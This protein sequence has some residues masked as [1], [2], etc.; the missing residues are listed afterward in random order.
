ME[1]LTRAKALEK[2]RKLREQLESQDADI[3]AIEAEIQQIED[4]LENLADA[5]EELAGGE[6]EREDQEDQDNPED[7]GQ[8]DDHKDDPEERQSLARQRA[9][10]RARVAAG[11]IGVQVRNFKNQEGTAM[12]N[13]SPASAEYRSGW[14]KSLQGKPLTAEERTAVS[15]SAAIP[16]ETVNKIWGKMEL[17][18]LFNAVDVMHIPGTVIL[19]VE[20]TVND[21]AVVAM[22]TAATDSA[23]SVSSVSL[24]A[25]KLIKTLEI[26]ADVAAMAIDAFENWLVD[27]LTNK[28]F[29]LVT[30]LIAAGTGSSQ[31]TGLTSI[32]ATGHTYTKAA[33][34]FGD[35]LAII[36]ALP[37]EYTPGASFLMSRATFYTNVLAIK[38][39][40]NNPIVVADPQAPAKFNILGYPVIIED[41]IGTDIVFGDLKEGYA[42]N[43]ASDVEVRRDESVGFRTGSTCFRGMALGDGKPTGVGLVRY[44][45]A[46]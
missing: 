41:E 22:G 5:A 16:Q 30:K 12:K 25:Y 39:S 4:A 36:A 45:K 33:I 43:F 24:G 9:Q 14:L 7:D 10:L 37:T 28:L 8:D 35:I 1:K 34:T 38:D 32:D 15:A 17:Y 18:P 11:M 42:W 3:E 6:E 21:A 31:P 20:G 29:R 26:T 46:T 19:P 23:D 2:L 27:R 40:N 13:Y 44:T